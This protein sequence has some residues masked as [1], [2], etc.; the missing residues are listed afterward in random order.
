MSTPQD[1]GYTRPITASD[2]LSDLT[3]WI[4]PATDLDD[5]FTAICDLTG[6]KL[7]VNG[8]ACNIVE[9]H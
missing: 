1:R 7:M 9:G 2:S 6:D 8:W 4:H 3:L 5:Q